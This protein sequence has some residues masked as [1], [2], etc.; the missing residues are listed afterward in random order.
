M[1]APNTTP[2]RNVPQ[3]VSIVSSVEFPIAMSI[4]LSHSAASYAFMPFWL[5]TQW[6]SCWVETKI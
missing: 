5:V 1:R 6:S 4:F 2:L 3:S